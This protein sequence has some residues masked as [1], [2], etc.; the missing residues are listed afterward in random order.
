MRNEYEIEDKCNIFCHTEFID[1][2]ASIIENKNNGSTV[3]IIGSGSFGIVIKSFHLISCKT[4]AIKECRY[5]DN[6]KMLELFYNESLLYKEF[7]FNK[8][9]IDILGFGINKDTNKLYSV[10]IYEFKISIIFN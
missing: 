1:Y 7:I 9:I 5:I 10:R 2:P 4:V 6:T 8:Y 3:K